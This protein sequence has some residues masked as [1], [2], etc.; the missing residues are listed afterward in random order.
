MKVL[1]APAHYLFSDK[2][3]SEP[4]WAVEIVSALSQKVERM[5]VI[6]GV[7][8]LDRQLPQNV[9]VHS[10]FAKRTQN[11]LEE[12]IRRIFFYLLVTIKGIQLLVSNRPDVVH[13][14]LPF[15][16]ATFNP[17]IILC[18]YFS[19]KTILVLG[20]VQAPYSTTTLDDLDIALIG[21]KSNGA[22]LAVIKV[23]YLILVKIIEH[24]SILMLKSI[25]C[26]VCTAEKS[27][28]YY[29]KY[30]SV[31]H[32]IIPPVINIEK[33]I[34]KIPKS[35]KKH[36]IL[37][38]GALVKRKGQET[39]LQAFAA[40]KSQDNST[41]VFVGDGSERGNLELMAKHLG[42]GRKVQFTGN[43]NRF[44]VMKYYQTA[45]IFCL[46]SS[47]DSY[48]TVIIEAMAYGLPIVA[49]NVGSIKEMIGSGGVVVGV[50]E[51]ELLAE[52]I[53][54]LV[55]DTKV[56]SH[57]SARIKQKY[58]NTFSPDLVSNKYMNVYKNH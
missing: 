3:G 19:P 28:Q 52:A 6:V 49:T 12:F 38:V 35:L 54:K 57:M 2:Y 31:E 48:P 47:E 33:N 56:Y 37:C 15:S 23:I 36:Q 17:L 51:T 43:L 58:A 4:L 20:P 16:M 7:S 27:W 34:S 39:L 32:V 5:D 25:D 1:I 41:L 8:E 46:T 29:S 10:I 30:T 22:I 11:V 18:K 55:M 21:R 9:Y 13:H 45:S 42:I 44:E 50:G 53:D 26:L 14:V 24:F 40:T